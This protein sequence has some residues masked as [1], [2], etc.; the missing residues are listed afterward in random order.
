MCKLTAIFSVI[1]Q[2]DYDLEFLVSAA[3]YSAL[4]RM[5]SE[6]NLLKI[7]LGGPQGTFYAHIAR[8]HENAPSS[9]LEPKV[10]SIN[11]GLTE[12][13]PSMESVLPFN[14]ASNK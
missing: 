4:Q 9:F 5:R 14:A 12:L 6:Q 1:S 7:P 13:L 10:S 8:S 11:F 2:F 3:K